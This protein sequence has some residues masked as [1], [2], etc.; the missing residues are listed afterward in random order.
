MKANLDCGWSQLFFYRKLSGVVIGIIL[1]KFK[2][3]NMF[4]VKKV[5][6]R[7]QQLEVGHFHQNIKTL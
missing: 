4:V 6:L 1:S 7:K 5:I 3:E 2:K